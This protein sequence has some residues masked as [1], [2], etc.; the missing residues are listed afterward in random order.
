MSKIQKLPEGLVNQIAAGEVI[1]RPSSVL[2]ELIEN[3]LDAQ[4]STIRINLKKGGKKQIRV[5]DNG[6]GIPFE[7]L[8]LALE[9]HTTSK[10]SSQEQLKKIDTLGFRGEALASIAA[11]SDLT[12]ISRPEEADLA[13]KIHSRGGETGKP[14]E[15]SA[16]AGTTVDVKNLFYHTPARKKFLKNVGT[17]FGRCSD[18]ITSFALAHPDIR[19]EVE[20]NGNRVFTLPECDTPRERIERFWSSNIS[21][22]L[23]SFSLDESFV[24]AR[25]YI[26][27]P[28]LYRTNTKL[29]RFFL[30]GRQIDDRTL[31]TAVKNAYEGILPPKKYPVVF[32]FLQLPPQEVD[33]NVHPTKKEVRF[34]RKWK[35]RSL[36]EEHI[37]EI[38]LQN[39]Q[40]PT[41]KGGLKE[42][43]TLSSTEEH[44]ENQETNQRVRKAIE[45]FFSDR[46][47]STFKQEQP[48]P[49][50]QT[51]SSSRDTRSNILT[52]QRTTRALQIHDSYILQEVED[53]LLLID[54][55]AL[56]ERIQYHKLHHR[57]QKQGIARQNLLTPAVVD[58]SPSLEKTLEEIQPS[59]KQIGF[60][61]ESF[62]RNSVALR[63]LPAILEGKDP[64]HLLTE[65]L[66]D[67]ENNIGA[68]RSH[69]EVDQILRLMAC[70]SAVKAGDSLQQEEIQHLLEQKQKLDTSHAC[71]H[72]RPTTLKLSLEELEKRFHRK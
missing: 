72:G 64:S 2:K 58:I 36:L 16:P 46:D 23:I 67:L 52:R 44:E 48:S 65:T 32:L 15:I 8:P 22:S 7:D 4:A 49:S 59:L 55:H 19:F 66:E 10:I 11:V 50:H 34:R 25:G 18:V 31:F 27:P 47:E 63:S 33:V 9:S 21:D 42:E 62:G 24:S 43:D 68:D 14:E 61:I 37:R 41:I 1:E 26:S 53:G 28:S 51:S 29:L 70:H 17:E 45:D 60:E 6:I 57:I 54:Q 30:N 39:K 71:V 5:E 12:I 40:T 69:G 13:G 38:V 56:H 35:L 20:H 3:A